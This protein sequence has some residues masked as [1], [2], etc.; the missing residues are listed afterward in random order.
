[1]FLVDQNQSQIG[2]WGKQRRPR[3]D[4]HGNLA[5]RRPFP[6]IIAFS[7][8]ETGI[9]KRDLIAK[10]PVKPHHRLICQRNFRDQQNHL[11]SI[12]QDTRHQL[13][14]DFCLS[15]SR[16]AVNQIRFTFPRLI[17]LTKT[18][19]RRLLLF[20]EAHGLSDWT[21]QFCMV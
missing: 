19:N 13:H 5:P 20:I 18:V 12:P 6:L 4:H 1:M 3:S 9:Q 15:T 8:R 14:V 10:S 11:L 21:R 7:R 17:I 2:K 16:N